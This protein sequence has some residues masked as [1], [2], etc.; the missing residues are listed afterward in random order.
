MKSLTICRQ[1]SLRKVSSEFACPVCEVPQ[2]EAPWREGHGSLEICS[3]CG[4]QFGYTDMASGD[5]RR[6]RDLWALWR[7]AWVAN[8][9]MPLSQEQARALLSQ[10]FGGRVEEP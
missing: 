7:Q 1:S 3:S 9:R 10:F 2:A 4:V 8:A 5:E 6:R